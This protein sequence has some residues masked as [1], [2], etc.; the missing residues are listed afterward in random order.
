MAKRSSEAPEK[1]PIVKN[2]QKALGII[3]DLINRVEAVKQ[4]GSESPL[5]SQ[6]EHDASIAVAN[7]FGENS[8]NHRRLKAI[9]YSPI[10]FSTN[11]SDAVFDEQWRAGL[12][13][14]SAIL[15]S[16]LGQIQTYWPDPPSIPTA[17]QQQASAVPT[18]AERKAF[19]V[20]GHNEGPKQGVARLLERLDI[21]PIILHEQPNQGKT[22]IEKFEAYSNVPFAIVIL[23]ADDEG[24][25]KNESSLR[26]RARQN[27]ILELGFFLGLLGRDK[28]CALY[29]EGVEIPSDYS[30][31]IFVKIDNGYAWQY[32][33]AKELKAAGISIDMNRI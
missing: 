25:A 21:Q 13:E 29:E 32:Q 15:N 14:A 11:T 20:H 6:W 28:V 18:T 33:V 10:V 9:R 4:Q 31:V 5:F 8:Q 26:A 17:H 1:E 30:G 16:F 2:K 7:I 3:G 24:K 23:T 27:V 19:I 22:I 12:A